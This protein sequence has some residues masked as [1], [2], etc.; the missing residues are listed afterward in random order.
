ML[1]INEDCSGIR[2]FQSLLMTSLFVGELFLLPIFFRISI[3]LAGLVLAFV[4][5]AIRVLTLTAIYF[6]SGPEA[7]DKYHDLVGR[8]AFTASAVTLVGIGL[9]SSHIY[10][11]LSERD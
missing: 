11:R 6:D 5:N 1:R 8:S 10:E 9:L 4:F 3:L 7:F 2:S